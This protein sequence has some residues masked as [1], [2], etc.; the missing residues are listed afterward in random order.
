MCLQ[1]GALIKAIDNY[2]AKADDDLA[3]R[4]KKE[5]FPESKKS[6]S[7]AKKMEDEVAEALLEETAVFTQATGRALDLQTFADDI[8]PGVKLNDSLAA[9]LEGVFVKRFTELMPGLIEAYLHQTD[10]EL[11]LE[12]VSKLTTSWI[13]EWSGQLAELMKL[14]SHKQIDEILTEGLK[15]GDSIAEFTQKILDSG[16]RDEYYRARQVSVTEVLRAH[17]VA[18]QEAFMQNP[19]VT[20]KLWRH[21]GEYR[22]TPRQNHVDMDGAIVDKADTFTLTGADG[23]TYHPQYPRDSSLPPGESVNCHCLAEPIVSEEVLGLSLE[24]RQALQQ[25]AIDEMDEDWEEAL[26]AENRAK[27]GLA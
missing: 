27:A 9:T 25:K 5:G 10:K 1:C 19:S 4:L 23:E 2:L 26:D 17:S 22:N 6:V 11:K 3:G 7:A 8:W 21:T 24:E 20:Q 18:Q 12:Q 14:D 15:N 13:S 16:I